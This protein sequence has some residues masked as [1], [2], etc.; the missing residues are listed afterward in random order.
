MERYS[1]RELMPLLENPAV[2][3]ALGRTRDSEEQALDSTKG[4]NVAI[5]VLSAML[6]LVPVAA[7]ADVSW[8]VTEAYAVFTEL[9]ACV[10]L[11]I[12]G[13]ELILLSLRKQTAAVSWVYGMETDK[14]IGIVETWAAQCIPIKST[15]ITRLLFLF[16][17]LGAILVGAGL[18]I[19]MR[20]RLYRKKKKTVGG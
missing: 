5:L 18:E 11:G 4:S 19:H 15:F 1:R 12:K 9:L 14:D 8:L 17:A 16:A 10:P 7:F 20:N 13:V 6:T 3:S 2:R